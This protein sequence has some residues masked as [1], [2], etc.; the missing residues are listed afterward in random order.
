MPSLKSSVG[1]SKNISLDDACTLIG[2]V[3]TEDELGQ[4]IESETPRQIF[5]SRISI[6]RAE[7]AAAGQIGLKAQ[8]ILVVDS[9]EYD[10]E[11]KIDYSEKRYSVYRDFMRTD[12]FTELYC[13][14]KSG[15]H[16]N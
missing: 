7:F 8:L 5:C 11:E 3:T 4:P 13:E 16:K 10:G 15:A 1:N 6:S 2:L 12:G 14:V 9:D